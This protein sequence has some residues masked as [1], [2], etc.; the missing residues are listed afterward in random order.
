MAAMTMTTHQQKK[1]SKAKT[2]PKFELTDEAGHIISSASSR[3]I[4]WDEDNPNSD[5]NAE[6]VQLAAYFRA[7]ARGFEPGHEMDDW[8]EAEKEIYSATA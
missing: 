8:L 3:S 1:T 4:R 2:E 6:A 5:C 7:E